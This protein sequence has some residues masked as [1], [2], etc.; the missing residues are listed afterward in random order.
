MVYTAIKKLV[1]YG[2]ETGLITETDRIYA[3]NQ[4]LE[5]LKLEEYEEPQDTVGTGNLEDILKELLD[6]ACEQGIIENSIAYRDLF[7]A[8]LMNC[9]M[10]RPSEV[11]HRTDIWI[12]PSIYLSRRR[13]ERPLR[14][15]SWQSRA[16]TPNACSVWRMKAMQAA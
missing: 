11:V 16:D 8:K 15:R 7:D 3:T 9:L 6:Y 2:L 13:I 1:Q 4:I 10:P 12:S 14:Q 5:A